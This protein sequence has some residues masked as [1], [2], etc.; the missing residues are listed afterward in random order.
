MTAPMPRKENKRRKIAII[1]GSRGEYGY[2]RPIIHEI[3]RRKNLDYAIIASNMHMLDTFGS[4]IDEI[5]RDRFKIHAA[6]HNT[7]DGYN[8]LTMAKS[9]A[10][11]M[12]Q[13]PE[14]LHQMDADMVLI[15]GDRGEQLVGAIVG[16]YMYIPVAHIQAGEVSGNIDGVTRH[17]ITK[18]AHLHFTANTDAAKRVLKMGEE[19]HRVFNIGA[20][21]LDELV[22]GIITPRQRIYKKFSL[23]KD[24]P[25]IL[26]V[27]HSVTEGVESL[28]HQI[29]ETMDAV[30]KLEYQTV[31]IL[32]NSD[33]GSNILRRIIMQEHKPFMQVHSN[34]KRQDYLGL[35]S[36]ADVLVGNSSSAILEAPTIKL[37]AV[38]IGS[39][40]KG[41]MQST[42]IINVGY[43]TSEILHAIQKTLSPSFKRKVEKCT[44]PYG[45]GQSSKR[46]VDILETIPIDEKLL[47]KHITY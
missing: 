33:A 31:I 36:V 14:L 12:L 2:Y 9:L 24:K 35:L 45:D 6:V 34:L 38:N 25:T 5:K 22:Q 18:F 10:I 42:N 28:E 26:L 39:R 7:L 13:L 1:A 21:Q 15:G 47:V 8:H 23:D 19:P 40:Q 46:I 27:Q 16:A 20:P 29:K 41:R 37:A 44:N 32:N 30:S 4:S 11:F 17:A 43:N 3:K